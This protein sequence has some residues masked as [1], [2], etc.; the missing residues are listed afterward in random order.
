MAIL[1]D[2]VLRALQTG[3]VSEYHVWDYA[4]TPRDRIWLQT[5]P[6]RHHA[7]RV[8]T[9]PS[10]DRHYRAY[11][12]H[13][14]RDTYR[15]TVFVKI[16]DDIVYAN[17]EQ[18]PAFLAF[19]IAHPGYFLVSANVVNNGVC[20]YFQQQQGVVPASL[21]DL[22]YP[23]RG[24][25]GTLWERPDLAER[26]HGYFLDA[27]DRFSTTGID[28]APDRLSI[29]FVSYLGSDLDQIANV[30]DD[31]EE[32]MSVTIPRRLGRTNVIFRPMVVSHLSFVAQDRGMRVAR[33]LR[34]YRELAE[35]G[36]SPSRPRLWD[37]VDAGLC[38]RTVDRMRRRI[39]GWRQ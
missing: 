39:R 33:L 22:P 19:R 38:G 21:M 30:G 1:L 35:T 23:E 10:S 9:P 32:E 16:D 18:L 14:R 29:N 3:V 17:L 8:L 6:E 15:D 2:Y 31:D 34:R 4:R 11:Y 25:C 37:W 20:A 13:Y 5:L 28:K 24:F 7:I 27:P 26:L 36:S 12:R